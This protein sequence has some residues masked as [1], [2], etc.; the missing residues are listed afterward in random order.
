[1]EATSNVFH[2]TVL[3][4]GF[5][6]VGGSIVAVG[7]AGVAGVTAIAATTGTAGA[8]GVAGAAGAAGGGIIYDY[9]KN[10]DWRKTKQLYD[11]YHPELW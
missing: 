1:M 11:D 8:A 7:A 10:L 3:A 5:V 6:L 2:A 4:G 9:L